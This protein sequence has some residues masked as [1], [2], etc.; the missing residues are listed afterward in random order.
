MADIYHLLVDPVVRCT[1]SYIC[2]KRKNAYSAPQTQA[3]H[4]LPWMHWARANWHIPTL[5]TLAYLIS[6]PLGIR[7]MRSRP[8]FNLT[9]P[10][11]A[12]NAA[13]CVFSALGAAATLPAALAGLASLSALRGT[14]C[15]P[16]SFARGS[17]GAWVTLFML[18]KGPELLDTAFLVLR[19]KP[20]NFLHW[21]HHSTVLA[22]CWFAFA[23]ESNLGL[24]FT[25]MNLIV[26]AVMYFYYGVHAAGWEP[27]WGKWVTRLQIAQMFAG[28]ALCV[29]AA[30]LGCEDA[31][32]I[33]AGLALYASYAVLFLNFYFTPRVGKGRKEKE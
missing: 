29:H 32:S 14:L 2:C 30:R 18:S 25:T 10:L 8:P 19:K 28:G 12:W 24:Y 31:R 3:F 1:P 7:C 4:T 6:L 21:Y 33:A 15:G 13:L 26:H 23:L 5:L 17:T 20:V 9:A 11:I 27:A 22:F 16:V